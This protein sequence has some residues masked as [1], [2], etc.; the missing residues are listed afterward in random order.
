MSAV[1][2]ALPGLDVPVDA[3]SSSFAKM[4]DDT[5]AEGGASPADLKATQLNFVLHFGFVTAP[6]DALEQFQVTLRFAQRYPCRVVVLCPQSPDDPATDMQAKIYGECFL[7][8]SKGDTRCV[9]F[10]ALSYPQAARRFLEN[11]VSICLSVDLPLYYWIHRF[12]GTARLPDYQRLLTRAKCIL[13]DRAI[14]TPDMWTYPWPRPAGVRDLVQA[15]LLH[16]R[17]G[18]GQFL[19]SY[20]PAV[21]VGGLRGVTVAHRPEFAAEGRVLLAWTRERLAQCGDVATVNYATA[22]LPDGAPNSL[23]LSFDYGG[24]RQF[25]WEGDFAHNCARFEADFGGGRTELPA[26]VSLLAPENALSEAI[27]F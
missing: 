9:E 19:A 3:I 21:L 11:E 6:K 8:K 23:E 18:I 1:F 2:D 4:W 10:V 17:Q 27:F 26:A 12:S 7:G 20:A 13:L 14:S 16:V 5:A 22:S 15:R 25:R 24:A